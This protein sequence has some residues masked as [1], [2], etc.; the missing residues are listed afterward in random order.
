MPVNRVIYTFIITSVCL[1]ASAGSAETK[2][3]QPDSLD[4][5]RLLSVVD[6]P[7]SGLSGLA[8]DADP[9]RLWTVSDQSGGRIYQISLTGEIIT[10]LFYSGD[11]MEGITYD[12]KSGTLWIVEERMREIVQLGPIGQ[13]LQRISVDIGPELENDGPEGIAFNTLTGHFYVA[14]ER[15]P[16]VIMELDTSLV[17]TSETNIAF[18]GG[19]A[20]SDISGLFHEPGRDELWILSDISQKIVV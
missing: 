19:F 7:V 6:L 2:S 14:N 15:N 16:M 13:V 8:L 10:E 18:E 17:I 20:I 5:I 11:D 4:A 12:A 9:Q 1:L 3:L